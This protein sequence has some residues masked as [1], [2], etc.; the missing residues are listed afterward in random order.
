M[1]IPLEARHLIRTC[2]WRPYSYRRSCS[3]SVRLASGFRVI[4]VF[5]SL[6]PKLRR[7]GALQ[8]ACGGSRTRSHRDLESP[9][10]PLSY[11]RQTGSSTVVGEPDLTPVTP[12]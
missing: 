8:D 11:A 12:T 5:A 3:N 2:E 1:T 6:N 9:A 7:A 10:L 4:R